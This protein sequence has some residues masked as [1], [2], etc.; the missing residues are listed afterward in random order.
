MNTILMC[1]NTLFLPFNQ[2][3]F[4]Q[5]ETIL[6]LFE[7]K[8]LYIN[9]LKKIYP[10]NEILELFYI[11][12][13]QRLQLDKV[14]V[15]LNLQKQFQVSELLQDLTRL[16]QSEP[17]Q[18]IYNNTI[19]YNLPFY[20]TPDVLIPR[21][22]TEEL[23]ALILKRI[24][25]I[26]NPIIF[27]IGTGSG[28]IAISL[29]KNLQN[30]TIFAT[31]FSQKAI[32]IAQKNGLHNNVNVTFIQ[33]DIFDHNIDFILDQST[34]LV[35]NPPY[36]PKSKQKELHKNVVDY[37]PHSALF[38]PD[39]DPLLFY[40][41]IADVAQIKLAEQGFLFFET[42]ELY[43]DEIIRY[44]QNTGFHQ[45]ESVQDINGN[46]RFIIAKKMVHLH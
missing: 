15:A 1:K 9:S 45:I 23:V 44:L 13:S 36:I 25:T 31:D 2:M 32:Q 29:A 37:E 11:S 20:V 33:H 18:Y 5:M 6:T 26:Q 19:F 35:S 41:R 7:L 16:E 43:H 34:V 10:Q 12:I 46:N 24:E 40:K 4:I 30:G 39:D 14:A 8:N 38:V 3:K 22:E 17:V 42:Y 28:A 27:D 21:P